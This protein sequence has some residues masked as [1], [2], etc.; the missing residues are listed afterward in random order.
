MFSVPA[1]HFGVDFSKYQRQ[2]ASLRVGLVLVLFILLRL[3]RTHTRPLVLRAVNSNP[4]RGYLVCSCLC[5]VCFLFVL[6]FRFPP[7]Y[8][9]VFGWPARCLVFS[10]SRSSCLLFLSPGR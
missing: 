9:R 4:S 1:L 8:S 7:G 3:D 10:S 2:R 6:F 5:L